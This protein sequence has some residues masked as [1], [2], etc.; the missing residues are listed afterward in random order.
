VKTVA[1]TETERELRQLETELKR[2][3]A[4]YNMFFAGRLARPPL[5]ARSRVQAL[6]KQYDRTSLQ[7][8]GDRFRFQTLQSRFAALAD[9]WDRGLRA[10]EEGRPG[11][12]GR[13]PAAGAAG[14]TSSDERVLCVIA[15]RDPRQ[16]GDRLRRLHE[17]LNQARGEVGEN[18]MPL[19]QFA[20]LIDEEL[21][22][23][24]ASGDVEVSFRIAVKNGR[25]HITADA[26]EG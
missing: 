22:R 15:L 9:L 23:V 24:N 13:K 20:Q 25:A 17:S 19:Q 21:A 1:T 8:Y 14:R 18:P 7:N 11:P 10:R 6:V 5:K 26:V 3:E 4:E 2:L 12:F 16:D